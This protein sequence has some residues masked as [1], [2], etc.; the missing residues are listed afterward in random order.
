M[1]QAVLPHPPEIRPQI[2]HHQR[3]RF[4][5]TTAGSQSVS[6]ANL[7]DT[8]FVAATAVTGFDLWDVVKVKRVEMWSSP[9]SATT[10]VSVDFP[11]QL[12]VG[13]GDG[14]LVSDT[15][16]GISPAHINARP[17]KFSTAGQWQGSSALVAFSLLN[18]PLDAVIDVECSFRN[19]SVAP[20]SVAVAPV[21]AQP[22]QF[23][24]RG[25]DGQTPAATKF[26]AVANIVG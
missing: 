21:A 5:C 7:L 14:H 3:M 25:L 2:T 23:Y 18:C 9:T 10:T 11:G 26:P 20:L 17:S 1:A 19:S 22:G 6:F 15:S 24:Y 4:R 16:M 13:A 8:M 12:G